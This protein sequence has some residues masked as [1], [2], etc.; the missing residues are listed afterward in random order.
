MSDEELKEYG[1]IVRVTQYYTVSAE[2][3]EDAEEAVRNYGGRLIESDIEE[4][5]EVFPV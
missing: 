1:V 4:V 5:V 2:S 3:S